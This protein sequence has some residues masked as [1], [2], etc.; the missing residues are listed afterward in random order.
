MVSST[1][2]PD[3]PLGRGLPGELFSS[4]I[5]QLLIDIIVAVSPSPWKV[6]SIGCGFDEP[7]ILY[8]P[9]R[10]SPSMVATI[11]SPLKISIISR[12]LFV[13]PRHRPS[14]A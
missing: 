12:P 10:V 5:E 8:F 1:E 6:R 13:I 2:L 3:N 9:S 11:E 14:S 7:Y 4:I